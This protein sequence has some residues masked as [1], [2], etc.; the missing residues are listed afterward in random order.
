MP[1]YQ[2]D[3]LARVVAMQLEVM[4]SLGISTDAKPYFYHVQE[5]FPYFTNR[6][7]TNP[8]TDDG[9]QD[10]DLN[11]P[12][13]SMRLIIAH[14]T[15]GYKGEPEAKL[16]EWLPPIKTFFNER[17]WL[18]SAAYPTRMDDLQQARVIDGGGMRWF[19]DSGFNV[20]QLGAEIQLQCIFPEF[21]EQ[22]YY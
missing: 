11:S 10:E 1:T 14:V 12:I 16:Y 22:A 17:M 2:T 13:V 20:V 8:I 19:N 5:D 3:L 7:A 15:E 9:S 18:Q 4:T 6:I 21:I